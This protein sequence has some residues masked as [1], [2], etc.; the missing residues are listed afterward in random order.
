M[1]VSI[2]SLILV[3]EPYFNEPGF[4]RSR[5]T[6]TGDQSSRDYSANIRVHCIRWA[7]TEMLRRPPKA[8]EDVVRRHFWMK[9]D[10]ICDR[11]Q[12]WIRETREYIDK[13]PTARS[14]P[15]HLTL[16]E[17]SGLL[18]HCASE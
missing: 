12:Q 17:V 6:P 4:E 3:P 2:Q 1:L 5:G 7:M 9:R 14:M 13:N 15:Q 16:M 8:F 10:V 11:I 18:S